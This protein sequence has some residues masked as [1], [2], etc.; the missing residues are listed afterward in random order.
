M[1]FNGTAIIKSSE[2]PPC[3]INHT[4]LPMIE[5][6]ASLYPAIVS[7]D[8]STFQLD[9]QSLERFNRFQTRT[10]LSIG[11]PRAARLFQN[12]I[13]DLAFSV[14]THI[15]QSDIRTNFKFCVQHPYVMHIVQ[16]LTAIHDRYLSVSPSLLHTTTEPYHLFRAAALF[17]RK[18]SAPVQPRDRDALWTTA[19]LL[20]AATLSSIEA[21]NPE[22]AWPLK[23]PEPSDLEWLGMSE[24]KTIIW[25]LTNPRRPDSVFHVLANEY[26]T[27]Y[28]LFS[29]TKARSGI[30]GIPSVF[31]QLYGLDNCSATNNSPYY[32]AVQA[33]APLLSIECDQSNVGI[34]LRFISHVQPEFKELLEKKD[35]R[36]LLALA[37]WYAKVSGSVWWIER[38]AI[39]ECQAICMYL[40]RYHAGESTIQ[41][42]LW[43]PKMRCG[44]VT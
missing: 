13:A 22:D 34:F 6:P 4:P 28:P 27:C 12:I 39:L 21:S 18:L 8:K 42:L 19:L 10:V 31:I 1:S 43:F 36:A 44:L 2:K 11:S 23:H 14:R 25:N 16:A 37:Y 26:K 3:P 41:E 24:K 29:A 40:E 17:N 38:R 33:L 5:A 7:D 15:D 35:P 32:N 20:G 9:R 30:E